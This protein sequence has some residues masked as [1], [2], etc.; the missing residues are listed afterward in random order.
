MN[1]FLRLPSFV[2]V[3]ISL[4]S[5]VTIQDV[6]PYAY[7]GEKPIYPAVHYAIVNGNRS[8]WSNST[9][10][11]PEPNTVI[12]DNVIVSDGLQLADF[13]LRISLENGVV[14]Y[15]FSNIRQK[16]PTGSTS[17][18]VPVERFSQSGRE[19]IFTNYFNAEI[20]KVMEN[21]A[22]YAQAKEAADKSL[23][24]A[25]GGGAQ[26]YS[27]TFQNPQN[28]LLYPAV[29]TAFN[30]LK[31]S[32]GEKTA[33]M[34]DI[35]CLHN[36]FSIRGCVA[37][38][39]P[40]DL[41]TYQIKISAKGNQLSIEFANIEP[42]G[43]NIIQY[44]AAEVEAMPRFDTQKTA[45][46]IKT[47]IER[48][49]ASA[50]VY[51]EAKKAFLANNSFLNRAFTTVTRVMMDEFVAELFKDGEVSLNTSILDVKKNSNSE[52]GNYTTLISAGLY[53]DPPGS[54]AFAFITLYTN[55]TGLA[56]LRQS[57]KI[58]LNGKL[59]RTEYSATA[60]PHFIMTK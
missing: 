39:R 13:S 35:F 40:G 17:N 31:R 32:L 29:G 57:E 21:D 30:N 4:A 12:I 9:A 37:E 28:F 55:D 24:G 10:A 38:R 15:Q 34:R 19:A 45:D 33:N 48:S 2:L 20:P 26:S 5:C 22:L 60:N 8:Y 47:Q 52:F 49:L 16:P 41:I 54:S 42:I 53:T 6:P 27:L 25:P 1:N 51:D 59:V 11:V 36:E 46:Q 7:N 43:S 18:W 44:S 23:G 3:I 50:A 14:K 56:R 58:T